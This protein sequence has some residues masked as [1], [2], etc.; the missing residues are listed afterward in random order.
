MSIQT[1]ELTNYSKLVLIKMKTR[2]YK[3]NQLGNKSLL[4]YLLM[5]RTDGVMYFLSLCIIAFAI[6]N[7]SATSIRPAPNPQDKSK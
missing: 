7:V 3:K 2:Q 6:H 1:T 4:L 5:N